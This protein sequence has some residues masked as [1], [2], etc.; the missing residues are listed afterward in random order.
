MMLS[1]FELRASMPLL[2]G[3]SV[4]FHRCNGVFCH[5]V[6]FG[7][8]PSQLKLSF[9]ISM[10]GGFQKPSH[11]FGRVFFYTDAVKKALPQIK[12]RFGII[13][14][15]GLQKPFHRLGIIFNIQTLISA[16]HA[17][18]GIVIPSGNDDSNHCGSNH[19]RNHSRNCGEDCRLRQANAAWILRNN[20]RRRNRYSQTC[21][22]RNGKFGTTVITVLR[23]TAENL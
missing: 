21:G 10:C 7:T 16:G 1:Q 23:I 15:G 22:Q 13:L 11:R 8:A 19:D 4:P 12:L 20:R 17:V 3:L 9:G 6:P 18:L 2:G 14:L 5:A